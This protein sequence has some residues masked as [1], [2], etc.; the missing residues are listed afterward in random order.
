M[1]ITGDRKTKHSQTQMST[2][3]TNAAVNQI[4]QLLGAAEA[5][6]TNGALNLLL[7]AIEQAN[8]G[9]VQNNFNSNADPSQFDDVN[10]GYSQSSLIY[11]TNN[12]KLWM[13]VVNT[14]NNA[15]WGWINSTPA[16]KSYAAIVTQ[17]GVTEPGVNQLLTN[18][19]GDT[20]TFSY[21]SPGNYTINSAGVFESGLTVIPV[22]LD[23]NNLVVT[24]TP[25]SASQ[26]NMSVV[27]GD[28]QI[29]NKYLEIR[30]YSA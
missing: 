6:T 14:A 30:V 24:F 4:A 11:N 5:L 22:M 21:V 29:S 3:S 18:T 28:N 17:N 16:Y 23:N 25:Q 8:G 9:G 27:G 10:A 1:M 19:L 26:I 13:C 2:L 7:T 20:V 15:Q 12:S